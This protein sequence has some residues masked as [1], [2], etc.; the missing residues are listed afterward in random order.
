MS[1]MQTGSYPA[2]SHL[3]YDPQQEER[4]LDAQALAEANPKQDQKIR[5]EYLHLE[6]PVPD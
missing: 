1:F 4:K 3:P 5:M 6:F 2:V